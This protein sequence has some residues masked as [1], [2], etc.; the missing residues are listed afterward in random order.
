MSLAAALSLSSGATG[1]SWIE[2]F[3]RYS[4]E[5]ERPDD[6][7]APPGDADAGDPTEDASIEPTEDATADATADATVDARV[8]GGDTEP[9]LPDAGPDVPVDASP[10]ACTGASQCIALHGPTATCTDG[11]CTCPGTR[12]PATGPTFRCVDLDDDPLH[13]G[14]CGK[15]CPPGEQCVGGACACMP[16][17]TRCGSVCY[18]LEGDAE[19]CGSCTLRCSSS[20]NKC[21]AAEP[22]S[23][24]KCTLDEYGCPAGR[25]VCPRAD[26]S[27]H[28][29]RLDRDEKNCGACGKSCASGEVCVSGAC[30]AFLPALGCSSPASCD[31]SWLAAGASA[32]P[33]LAGGS[34]P[35]CVV[36]GD[37]PS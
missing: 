23:G 13:C 2:D 10:D 22:L 25:S 14:A 19:H 27:D 18:D 12:C 24:Y 9:D 31:C 6:A 28:C 16:G 34:V 4:A 11:R 17:F 15:A 35:I 29:F 1:C 36:G 20:I 26:A 7:T 3:D 5:Y 21:R 8:D 32:C 30:R 37:C 33:A